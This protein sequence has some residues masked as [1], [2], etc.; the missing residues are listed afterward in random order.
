MLEG[1]TLGLLKSISTTLLLTSYIYFVSNLGSFFK[2]S[3][4]AIIGAVLG[5]RA[6]LF[7][8]AVFP[9]PWMS[10]ISFAK[11]SC[12]ELAQASSIPYGIDN[13]ALHSIK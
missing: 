2:V 13:R 6:P 5:V 10:T 8:F 1:A 11:S 3:L 7:R 4:D 12:L 9:P